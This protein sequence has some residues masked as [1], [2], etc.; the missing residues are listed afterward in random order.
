METE[1]LIKVV[2]A[3][4]KDVFEGHNINQLARLSGV[5]VA[6][7]HRML[8]EMEKENLVLKKISGNNVF[9]RPN[10]RN[11]AML[12]YCELSSIE[13]RKKF[14]L[15]H[16]GF[17]GKIKN[18]E[19]KTECA[20]LFGSFARNEKRPADIDI[21]LLSGREMNVKLLEREMRKSDISPLYME[22]P[23]FVEKLKKKNKVLLEIMRDGVVLFRESRYWELL[24]RAL[25]EQV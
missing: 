9:Y 15:K 18:L 14:L 7:M 3:L 11:S 21:L 17:Y 5:N 4:G 2:E 6:T 23:E 22:F 19:D 1:K 24:K 13:R 8:K 20:V 12:K 16:P 25:D 10:L